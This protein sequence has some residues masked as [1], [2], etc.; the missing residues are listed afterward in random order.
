MAGGSDRVFLELG[1]L[2]TER[3]HKVVP[4]CSRDERN[5]PSDYAR[6]FPPTI[7]TASPG[8]RDI[9][10]FIYS[11]AARARMT[12]LLSAQTV[13]LAHLHIY[14]GK[15]TAAILKPL[16]ERGIPIVQTLHEYKL[17][18]P[19]YTLTS[20][21]RP[22]EA[23]FGGRYWQALPRLCNRNSLSRTALS[24]VESYVSRALGAIDS[25]DHFIAI[26]DYVRQKMIAAGLPAA[27]ISTVHNYVDTSRFTPATTA[28]DY[29]VFFGRLETVKGVYS[30]LEAFAGLPQVRLVIAGTGG[31]EAAVRAWVEA[32][33]LSNIELLGFV[34]GE[35]L[36]DL[37]RGAL[38]TVVPSEW[39]EP[40][41]LTVLESLALAKPVVAT[42]MGGIP[43]VVSH[44]E[45]GLLVPAWDPA[46]LRAAVLELANNPQR[47]AAMGRAGRAK[48]EARFDRHQH[49]EQLRAVYAAARAHRSQVA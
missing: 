2:L 42:D 1:E 34:A 25:V 7:D 40:F 22:C 5:L 3:G 45:D 35:Q 14:Y 43:E 44:G 17:A 41:G 6:Y 18:C 10:R 39:Q 38:C 15:L 24:V 11:R 33:G 37:L 9:G 13:D 20:A 21:G 29:V 27:R 26:S 49:Y 8:V 46:A 4:F 48:V 31:E 19:V 32:R 36:H 47:A 23:C 28:G 12:E 30:L 16:R